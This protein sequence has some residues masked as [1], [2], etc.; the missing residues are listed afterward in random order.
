MKSISEL[1]TYIECTGYNHDI[2]LK[3]KLQKVWDDTATLH[4]IIHVLKQELNPK[5]V[6]LIESKLPE[7]VEVDEEQEEETEE[8]NNCL[9]CGEPIEEDQNFCSDWCRKGY[10]SEN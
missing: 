4:S 10:Q 9:F 5:L 2:V 6:E 8:E 7:M 3:D 1:R